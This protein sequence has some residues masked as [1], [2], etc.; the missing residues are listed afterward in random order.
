MKRLWDARGRFARKNASATIDPAELVSKGIPP[1]EWNQYVERA[2]RK[3]IVWEKTKYPGIWQRIWK[4]K[5]GNERTSYR[6]VVSHDGKQSTMTFHSLTKAREW[7]AKEDSE[8]ANNAAGLPLKTPKQLRKVTLGQAIKA[9]M[10][11]VW[12]HLGLKIV[13]KI[14]VNDPVLGNPNYVPNHSIKE[15]E[16]DDTNYSNLDKFQRCEYGSSLCKKSIYDVDNVLTWKKYEEW[17]R[18]QPGRQGET[19]TPRTIKR[20]FVSIKPVFTRAIDGTLPSIFE[21]RDTEIEIGEHPKLKNPL[22]RYVVKGSSMGTRS[23]SLREGEL[24]KIEA[25]FKTLH[26]RNKYYVPLAF[27]LAIETGMRLQE[28][29]NLQWGDIDLERRIIEITKSKTDDKQ[30]YLGRK[31]VLPYNVMWHLLIPQAIARETVR[32]NKTDWVFPRTRNNKDP[33]ASFKDVWRE[34]VVKRSG[35][36]EAYLE[37][38]PRTTLKD[39]FL[40]FHDLRRTANTNFLLAKLEREEREIMLGHANSYQNDAYLNPEVILKPIRDKLD[41]HVL[42]GLTAKE[43]TEKII[44]EGKELPDGSLLVNLTN[45]PLDVNLV[46]LLQK[47]TLR[48]QD[49]SMKIEGR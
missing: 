39:A 1:N 5:R 17:L 23:R 30:T 42:G 9:Y 7:K 41:R 14:L 26:G 6:V 12:G 22:D 28:I 4:D 37:K 15:R 35:I 21:D 43:Y 16:I 36:V 18:D 25:T 3:K 2:P 40:H 20:L 33:R 8:H 11:D 19:L 48:Y 31:I 13:T 46:E 47:G 29:I 24:E 38:Y 32:D 49:I 45:Y 10:T 44:A 27:Y 34:D